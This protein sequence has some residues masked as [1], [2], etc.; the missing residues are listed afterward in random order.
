MNRP[1]D[2]LADERSLFPVRDSPAGSLC[3][4]EAQRPGARAA[5]G[6]MTRRVARPT[7]SREIRPNDPEWPPL[8]D[9]LGPLRPPQQLY[10]TGRPL[11]SSKLSVA[12]VGTRRPTAA[13]VEMAETIARGLVEAGATVVSGLAIG[14]DAVAHRSAL[15]ADGSTVGVL[16]CGLAL[17]YP[18]KN[19]KLRHHL[20]RLGTVVTEYPDEWPPQPHQFPERNRIIVGLTSAVV[21]VEGGTQS[22]ALITARIALDANRQVFAVPGSARN[23]MA[24][25][26]NRL[27]RNSQ[28]SVC[29]SVNDIF[30]EL[31]PGTL[32][33]SFVHH[34]PAAIQLDEVETDVLMFL[35][36]VPVAI[37]RVVSAVGHPPGAVAL[38]LSKL[39][40][41]GLAGRRRGGY[42]ITG[43]GA[44]ARAAALS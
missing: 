39:E 25:G 18:A 22:G 42:E 14:I 36:D 23:A 44:R 28:A 24:E 11:D 15:E 9:E 31:A 38:A 1:R 17:D 8:L 10:A 35:D 7:E 4:P 30:D 34:A 6:R 40:V 13:G 19:S 16:G 41:R 43:G 26:P 3:D 32:H 5:T 37:D 33:R 2:L 12:V 27:I 29:T 21:V 20:S